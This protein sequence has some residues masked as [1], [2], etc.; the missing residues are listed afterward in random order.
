[1]GLEVNIFGQK[2]PLFSIIQLTI[3]MPEKR[4]KSVLP[5]ILI[6]AEYLFLFNF[7]FLDIIDLM[8]H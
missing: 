6:V 2:K 7:F 1:M 4:G 8:T 3:V 5:I